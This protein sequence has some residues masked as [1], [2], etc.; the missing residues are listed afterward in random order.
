[1]ARGFNLTAQLNLRG[2]SNIKTV[3]ADIRREIG[4]IDA[5]INLK[6][7]PKVT[8][9]ISSLNSALKSLNSTLTASTSAL[10]TTSAA[11]RNFGASVNLSNIKNFPQLVN[12]ATSAVTK[13]GS[14]SSSAS[15]DMSVVTNQMQEFGNQSAL[16]II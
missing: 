4:T 3:V 10:N 12:N 6:F 11:M 8:G 5:N 7:D 13:L 1:M 2:P 14:S 15:K 9:N 16:A